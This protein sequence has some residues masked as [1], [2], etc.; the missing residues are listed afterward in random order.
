[1]VSWPKLSVCYVL[2]R[3]MVPFHCSE[4]EQFLLSFQGNNNRL[5]LPHPHITSILGHSHDPL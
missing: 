4:N 1:M 3:E 5:P 2:H